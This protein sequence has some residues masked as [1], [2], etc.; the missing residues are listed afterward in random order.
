MSPRRAFLASLI[1]PGYAQTVFGRGKAAMLFSIVEIGAIG[2]ARKAAIDL[3]EA[4]GLPRDSVVAT[5][6]I[7][8]ATGLAIIDPKTGLPLPETWIASRFTDDRIKARRTHYEDWIAA[9]VFNHLIAAAE[10]QR[11]PG[12]A[13]I[14]MSHA[15]MAGGAV[16]EDSER[17]IVI[18]NAEAL[19]ASLFPEPIAYVAL[20]HLHKPQR[21]AGQERIR[22]SGSP[23]PLSFGEI[24][25]PHQ[26]LLASFDGARLSQIESLPVPRSVE[27]VRIG[28]AP[29]AQ[30]I[31]QLEA[32]PPLGLFTENLP[33]LEVRVQLDEPLPDL[34]QRIET[35]LAGKACRL[36]RIA[37]EYAGRRGEGESE[38]LLGLDQITPRELFARA[39]EAQFGNPPDDQALDDFASLLQ[40]V[41][42]ASE[43]DAR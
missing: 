25:Y 15:H 34:R 39:W 27:M 36:V 33:W 31:S 42:L 3:A 24:D 40:G 32:L 1:L 8:P 22:Y 20:G 38:V 4:K 26:V 18:G 28:R 30:V 43:G 37:S 23:L 5:Y 9:I 13:L 29:L 6:Q 16:S 19:P 2:M 10:A 7:D 12:Q 35:A 14:A 17:N 41:E 21:V 11:Q